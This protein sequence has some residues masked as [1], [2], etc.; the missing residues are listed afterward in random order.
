MTVKPTVSLTDH[1]HAFAKSLVEAGSYASLS[2]VVQR[3]LHLVEREEQEHR[4]RL[5][6]IRAD[7]EERR[8]GEMIDLET[9][10]ANVDAMLRE[11]EGDKS[12]ARGA[13]ARRSRA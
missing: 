1:A 7:L 12:D 2:A 9:F 5:D 3:G 6:A 11:H 10:E 4:A 8:R 13:I